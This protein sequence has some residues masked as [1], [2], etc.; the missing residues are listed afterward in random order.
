M[1]V[2]GAFAV[3]IGLIKIWS[4]VGYL[5]IAPDLRAAVPGAKFLPAYAQSPGLLNLVFW[6]EALVGILGLWRH[7]HLGAVP[8]PALP[9]AHRLP[10]AAQPARPAGGSSILLDPAWHLFQSPAAAPDR[11]RSWSVSRT[12]LVYLARI[13]LTRQAS[14]RVR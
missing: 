4:G 6:G 8:Q 13:N 5:I 14:I 2:G 7:R 12:Y 9:A 11:S 1:G 10:Q 3:L